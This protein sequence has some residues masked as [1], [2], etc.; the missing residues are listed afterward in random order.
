METNNF[1]NNEIQSRLSLGEKIKYFFINPQKLFEDYMQDGKYA[2]TMLIVI[3]LSVIV[4]VVQGILLRDVLKG[5]VDSQLNT[6]PGM[7]PAALGIAQSVANVTTSPIF[8]AITTIVGTLISI[9][10][11]TLIYWLVSKIFKGTASYSQMVGVYVISR[12]AVLIGS[13]INLIYTVIV[14]KPIDVN[15]T[16]NLSFGNVLLGHLNVFGIWQMVLLVIGIAVVAGISK[17]KSIGVVVI[18]W[19]LGLMFSLMSLGATN[20]LKGI[21]P[22][23][24]PVP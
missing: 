19:A 15:A 17:K 8:V 14:N 10:F 7:D 20:A 24:P 3:A 21:T 4:A 11:Y 13:V 5:A 23:A 1:E 16:A 22:P 9:Y 18:I 6:M 2:I 12:F